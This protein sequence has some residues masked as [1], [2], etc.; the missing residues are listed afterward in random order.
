MAVMPGFHGP[1]REQDDHRTSKAASRFLTQRID[2]I[3]VKGLSFRVKNS[4]LRRGPMKRGMN[5][6][7][8]LANVL[9]WPGFSR[10]FKFLWLV[11][12]RMFVDS[13]PTGE[14]EQGRLG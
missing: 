10:K 5:K 11:E 4:P 8:A 6:H 3:L 12:I 1:G 13:H 2:G 9:C 14:V 7:I